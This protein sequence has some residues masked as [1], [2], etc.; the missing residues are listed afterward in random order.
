VTPLWG[1]IE[2]NRTIAAMMQSILSGDATVE[3]ATETAS[4]E[5]D[6]VFAGG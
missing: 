2:G 1:A 3:E 5:M 6:D 4:Q